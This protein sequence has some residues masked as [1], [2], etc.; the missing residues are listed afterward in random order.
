[1]KG[2]LIGLN[3][4][5]NGIILGALL[6]PVVGVIAGVIGFLAVFDDVRRSPVYQGILG[7]T[8]WAMPM[9]WL[10]NALG[11]AF[12]LV[13]VVLA[14]VTLN[15]VPALKIDY[16]HID[17]ATGSIIM[18]GGLFSNMNPI[19]TAY[20]MGNFVFVDTANTAPDDDVPHEL[21]HTLSLAIFGSVVHLIG[22]LDEMV[23]GGGSNAWTERMADSHS[24]GRRAQ[25]AAAG[26][27]PDGTWA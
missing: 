13:S 25:I 14:G 27:T 8:N 23:L 20:D 2:F 17:W 16:I 24:P 3:A 7:W 21:G 18:K 1:M 19:N 6:G 4:G 11:L 10:V 15:K 5:L 9:S 12:F 26:G 22:F